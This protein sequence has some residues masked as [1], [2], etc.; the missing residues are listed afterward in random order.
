[1]RSWILIGLIL[2]A[3]TPSTPAPVVTPTQ[4]I[5]PP[6]IVASTPTVLPT[7][8]PVA[9]TPNVFYQYAP[10]TQS[11]KRVTD[12]TTQSV[13]QSIPAAMVVANQAHTTLAIRTQN[14]TTLIV[15]VAT[16]QQF[17]P[18]DACDSMTWAPDNTTLWCMRFGYVYAIDPATQ[19]DQ[20]SIAPT[21]TTYWAGLTQHPVTQDYWMLVAEGTQNKLCQFNTTTQTLGTECLDAGQL[22]RWSPDGQ[23]I[24]SI[25]D[26]Q[27]VITDGNNRVVANVGLGDMVVTQLTWTDA[28]QL[29]ITTPTRG[30]GYKINDAR[31]SLQAS[32]VLIVG[33]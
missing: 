21:D 29:A 13:A 3:C 6:T 17:G 23:L 22:P 26:R 31:I 4:T 32:D 28:T 5:V 10:A 20:L 7:R 11:L 8:T 18:F 24:A 9:R 1:M 25:I 19:T 15:N 27:L 33:R 16:A 2:A 30:Y 14:D 12:T